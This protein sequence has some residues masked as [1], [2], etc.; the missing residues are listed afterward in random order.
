[1]DDS[2]SQMLMRF[3]QQRTTPVVPVNRNG[4]PLV[5]P[6]KPRDALPP[7][8]PIPPAMLGGVRG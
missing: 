2:I 7:T 6:P 5:R 4:F 1:M 8:D 3:L